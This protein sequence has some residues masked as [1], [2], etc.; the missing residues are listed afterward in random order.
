MAQ[1][2]CKQQQFNAAMQR[3]TD[4]QRYQVFS[5]L[6]AVA[7][8]S[9]QCC[10]LFHAWRY[11]IGV[12]W[13]ILAILVAFLVTDFI[14]GLVHMF[15]DNNDRYESLAGPLIANFHL[16]HKTPQYKKRN[17]L[18]VYFTETG[19]KVW[20]V[21]YLA[22]ACLSA[23]F[24]RLPPLALFVLAYVGILSSVAEVSHYL[25]HSST[26]TVSR[27]LGTSG[28]LLSKRHHAR[29][30]LQDNISYAFL[31]GVTD[32]LLN[33]IAARIYKGYKQTTDLHYATYTATETAVR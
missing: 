8:L 12:V 18:A 9:L 21:G 28:I 19:S 23:V 2:S 3:Y 27:L 4:L 16:H 30:H 22:V 7:N 31:N 13:Q 11:S 17:L 5:T 15:M 10:L 20:L 25:C 26:S 32:P 14:N 1:I 33:L 6:V 29:H 24:F